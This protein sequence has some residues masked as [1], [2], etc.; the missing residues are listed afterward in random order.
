MST[1]SGGPNIVTNGLVLNIDAANTKSYPGSGTTWTDISRGGNNG[2]LVNGPTFNSANGGSI[3]FDG[4][5]DYVNCGNASNL[6]ITAGTISAWIKATSSLNGNYRAIICKQNAWGLFVLNNVLVTFDW[7]NATGRSTSATVGN[8]T[9]YNVC[10]SFTESTGTPSNN[11][12]I[13]VN[14][15]PVLTTTI[16]HLNQTVNC[17]IGYGNFANQYMIGNIAQS[18]IYNR[19]LSGAEVLQNYNA[20]KT[21][22]GL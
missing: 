10:M 20:T 16:K 1:L 19:A 21:R 4:S 22:F 14:G 7:G 9:W 6:Q 8:S 18:K 13:Y 12:I 5:D 15:I 2:I 17:F 3:I 11:T